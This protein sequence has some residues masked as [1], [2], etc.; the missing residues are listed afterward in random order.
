MA[1]T[2]QF[3]VRSFTQTA[4]IYTTIFSIGEPKMEGRG[5]EGGRDIET[6]RNRETETER[7]L[8]MYESNK[9]CT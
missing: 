7:A 2:K 5:E 6:G 4:V 1:P 8:Y 9:Y 3:R